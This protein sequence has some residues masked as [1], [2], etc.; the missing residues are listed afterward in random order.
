[1]IESGNQLELDF[2]VASRPVHRLLNV[3]V[4]Q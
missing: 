2:V 3:T 4:N 1:V